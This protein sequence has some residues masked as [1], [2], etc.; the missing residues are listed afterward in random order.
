MLPASH[1]RQS[2]RKSEAALPTSKSS[3]SGHNQC[4][5][6]TGGP[7]AR[8]LANQINRL[9]WREWKSHFNIDKNIQQ[10]SRENVSGSV[11][12][13]YLGTFHVCGGFFIFKGTISV[14]VGSKMHSAPF[15]ERN[16]TDKRKKTNEK[17]KK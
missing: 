10:S 4:F 14:S 13:R 15:M 8:S 17:V 11:E 1:V 3:V 2:G 12:L 7:L 5:P 16:I 6:I 9:Y